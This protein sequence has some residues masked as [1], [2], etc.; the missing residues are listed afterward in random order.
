MSPVKIIA[1]ILISFIAG[2]IPFGPI[3]ARLKHIDLK[4]IGSGNIG[5]TNVYRALGLWWAVLVFLLDALKGSLASLMGLELLEPGMLAGLCG[6]ASVLGHAFS[7][8]L[9][10]QGGKGVATGFGAMVVIAPAPS[11]VALVRP[12]SEGLSAANSSG[13][14]VTCTSGTDL[15]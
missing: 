7:P 3:I 12:A 8:F 4:Q 5:A 2:A 9:K 15:P 10:F 6:I 13:S 14:A 1:A 11:L